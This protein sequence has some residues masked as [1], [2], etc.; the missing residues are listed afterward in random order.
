MKATKD[1]ELQSVT[2]S[3]THLYEVLFLCY[4]RREQAG[5]MKTVLAHLDRVSKE[6]K[7][8]N[9]KMM[10]LLETHKKATVGIKC[11]CDG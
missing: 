4:D 10:L 7:E 6:E 5:K 2:E 11:D 3:S 1:K 8:K 9:S